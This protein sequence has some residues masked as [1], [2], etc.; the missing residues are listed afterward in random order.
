MQGVPY[1]QAFTL[2]VK[3]QMPDIRARRPVVALLAEA[4]ERCITG[5]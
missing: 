2:P 4:T 5:M 3:P 1:P